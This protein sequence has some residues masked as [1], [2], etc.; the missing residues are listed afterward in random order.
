MD[1]ATTKTIVA[2]GG[3]G[4]GVEVVDATCEILTAAGFPL[5]ILTPPHGE[6]AQRSHGSPLPIET[7]RLCD[8]ADGILFGA[9]GSPAS[10]AVVAYLRRDHE[11][12]RPGR[13]GRAAMNRR[14]V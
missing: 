14:P 8:E 7:R 5:K 6:A 4:T 13:S 9:A 1:P 2:L 3:E 12:A 10:S 11:G